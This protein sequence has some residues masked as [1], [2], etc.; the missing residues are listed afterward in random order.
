KNTKKI[1]YITDFFVK[2]KKFII[3]CRQVLEE[4][5]K[6][7]KKKIFT[8][9]NPGRVVRTVVSKSIEEGL[10]VRF[11]GIEGFIRLLDISWNNQKEAMATYKRGQ[12]I[13]CKIIRIDNETE[14]IS[15][16]IKQLTQNP[17]DAVKR[18]FPHNSI[19]QGKV[20]SLTDQG[21]KI[22]VNDKVTGF[23]PV[24]EYGFKGLPK[25]NEVIKT[26]VV[27]VNSSTFELN[28]SIKKFEG[29]EDRK[30]MQSYMKESPSLTL[31]QILQNAKDSEEG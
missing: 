13:K 8:E 12:R 6:E 30:R 25:E 9:I 7:R 29:L 11:Q 23:I 3:S 10:F 24:F 22:E 18:R 19:I 21:A 17:V 2:D 16:G 28:L 31:G 5:E 26:V 14:R 20:I 1:F 27:G 15:F 4:D